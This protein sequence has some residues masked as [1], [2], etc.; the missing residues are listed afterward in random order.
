[1][2]QKVTPS[3]ARLLFEHQRAA[4][5]ASEPEPLSQIIVAS[6]AVTTTSTGPD[7]APVIFNEFSGLILGLF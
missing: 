3:M 6:R 5:V 7:G 4:L 1:M 2:V